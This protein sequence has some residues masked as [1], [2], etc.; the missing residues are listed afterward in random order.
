MDCRATMDYRGG[1]DSRVAM[2][3]RAE[4]DCRGRIDYR[5]GMEY[6]GGMDSRAEMHHPAELDYRVKMDYHAGMDYRVEMDYSSEMDYRVEMNSSRIRAAE[7]GSGVD[8][9]AQDKGGAVRRAEEKICAEGVR[10]WGHLHPPRVVCTPRTTN[11]K[12][13]QR[14]TMTS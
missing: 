8:G 13:L 3:Y 9:G 6:R 7:F 5:G 10:E 11:R 4:M 12:Q 14:S 1:M 2:D